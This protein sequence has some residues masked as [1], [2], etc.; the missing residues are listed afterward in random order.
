MTYTRPS[1]LDGIAMSTKSRTPM[2]TRRTHEPCEYQIRANMCELIDNI[3]FVCYDRATR[4]ILLARNAKSFGRCKFAQHF[5]K[6]S[7]GNNLVSSFHHDDEVHSKLIR[8]RRSVFCGHIVIVNGRKF[9]LLVRI[10]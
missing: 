9:D 1:P 4:W 5:A 8:T 10:I 7:D 3:V 6:G 2:R